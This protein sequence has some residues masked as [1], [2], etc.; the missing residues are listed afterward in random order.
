[1]SDRIQDGT[2][3][4]DYGAQP[5]ADFEAPAESLAER[6]QRVG[7]ALVITREDILDQDRTSNLASTDFGQ[8]FYDNMEN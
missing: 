1:M 6:M 7:R 4:R 2:I 3:S 5:G 8:A